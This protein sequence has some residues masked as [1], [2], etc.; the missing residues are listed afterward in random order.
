MGVGSKISVV[1]VTY[2]EFKNID[3]TRV[4]YINYGGVMHKVTGVNFGEGLL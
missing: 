2:E 4:V 1:D 3:F